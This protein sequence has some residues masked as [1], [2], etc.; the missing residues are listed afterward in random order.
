MNKST[1]SSATSLRNQI[2]AATVG[3]KKVFN[4]ELVM[5]NGMQIE[6]RQM[7]VKDRAN[8]V[9]DT[10]VEGQSDRVDTET[11]QIFNIIR[12]CFVPGTNDQIFEETDYEVLASQPCRNWVDTLSQALMRLNN[13]DVEELEK[14]S[15]TTV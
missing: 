13:I 14:N 15:E 2:R 5:A 1:K 6:C 4:T 7:S 12:N 3:S 11:W 9:A 8:L 10:E